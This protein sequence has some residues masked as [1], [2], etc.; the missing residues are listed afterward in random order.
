MARKFE[1][2][3]GVMRTEKQYGEWLMNLQELYEEEPNDLTEE[4][5]TALQNNGLIY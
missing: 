5:F 4:E 3:D 2:E 1:C